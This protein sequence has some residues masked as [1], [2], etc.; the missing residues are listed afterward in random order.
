MGISEYPKEKPNLSIGGF[1]AGLSRSPLICCCVLFRSYRLLP[2]H[3]SPEAC[4]LLI[5]CALSKTILFGWGEKWED[6]K[7]R[8]FIWIYSYVLITLNKE[9][10]TSSFFFHFFLENFNLRRLLLMIAHYHQN[11]TPISFW[12]K[13]ELNSRSLIQP[14]KTN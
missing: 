7:G 14:S 13:R 10:I 11:K 4:G 2:Y 1:L 12:C 8:Y 3:R 5:F 6:R 9:N